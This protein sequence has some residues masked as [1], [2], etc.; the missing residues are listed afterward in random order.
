DKPES[1]PA[2][3]WSSQSAAERALARKQRRKEA[4]IAE[5][6]E[7]EGDS[8]IRG[9]QAPV[10]HL[11]KADGHDRPWI[12]PAAR[13]A[14][15]Q[16]ADSVGREAAEEPAASKKKKKKKATISEVPIEEPAVSSEKKKKKKATISEVPIEEPA[17]IKKK[18]KRSE[19]AE[20]P[21]V[22]K[23]KAKRSEVAEVPLVGKKKKRKL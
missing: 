20:E 8:S 12:G 19:V 18:A 22:I 6:S 11:E 1:V 21:A 13:L 4:A 2:A 3:F 10:V 14:R 5:G 9:K 23:K 15:Q 7:E 17:V 16:A